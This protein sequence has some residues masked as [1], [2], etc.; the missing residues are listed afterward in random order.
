MEET[1]GA[2]ADQEAEKK[3]MAL[4]KRQDEILKQF[5]KKRQGFTDKVSLNMDTSSMS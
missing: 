3:K 4:K 5:Q 2:S 1:K